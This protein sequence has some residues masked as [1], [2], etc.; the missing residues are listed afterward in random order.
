VAGNEYQA[1]LFYRL[2]FR[3]RLL[4]RLRVGFGFDHTGNR[5]V[6]IEGSLLFR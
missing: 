1:R 4:Q 3:N 6:F 5:F 2:P